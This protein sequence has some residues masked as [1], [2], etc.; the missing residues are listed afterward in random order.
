MPGTYG[1]LLEVVRKLPYLGSMGGLGVV[2][3]VLYM[4]GIGRGYVSEWV[5]VSEWVQIVLK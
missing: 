2:W 4:Q 5:H 1:G 3:G